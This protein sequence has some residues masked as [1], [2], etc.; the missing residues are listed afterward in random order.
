[1]KFS[2]SDFFGFAGFLWVFLPLLLMSKMVFFFAT[3]KT[4]ILNNV[5]FAFEV[6]LFNSSYNQFLQSY[7]TDIILITL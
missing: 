2:F 4:N 5:S 3:F 7:S 6:F 1:M